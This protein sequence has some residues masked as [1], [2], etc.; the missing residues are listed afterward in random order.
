MPSDGDKRILT[1]GDKVAEQPSEIK[2]TPLGGTLKA[3]RGYIDAKTREWGIRARAR[4]TYPSNVWRTVTDPAK[5]AALGIPPVT[6]SRGGWDN[7][8]SRVA[9]GEL[10]AARG[11]YLS[12]FEDVELAQKKNRVLELA[13][14]YKRFKTKAGRG[15]RDSSMECR[16]LLKQIADEVGEDARLEAVSRSGGAPAP[17]M[18]P[19]LLGE[20]ACL[21]AGEL[22]AEKV[23]ESGVP[24]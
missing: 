2:H 7:C 3:D 19:E 1:N 20:L 18:T 10:D 5:C 12:T 6:A 11:E 13:K 4:G 9:K 24:L 21:I 14:L 23:P 8:M 22:K 16:L 15:D 17:A